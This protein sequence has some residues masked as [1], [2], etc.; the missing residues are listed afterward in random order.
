MQDTIYCF[1]LLATRQKST[2]LYAMCS[3]PVVTAIWLLNPEWPF[4]AGYIAWALVCTAV[5]M[6]QYA[7]PLPIRC[8]HCG[9][10]GL[11]PA[12]QTPEEQGRPD[13]GIMLECRGLRLLLLYGRLPPMAGEKRSPPSR[14]R[15]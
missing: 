8:P 13:T 1:H 4:W 15:G 5:L 10:A 7:A 11:R 14:F 2:L 3:I 6:I 12:S 9:H